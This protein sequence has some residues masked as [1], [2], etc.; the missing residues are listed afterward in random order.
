MVTLAKKVSRRLVKAEVV[1][2]ENYGCS[3]EDLK[4][5]TKKRFFG[6][7]IEHLKPCSIRGSSLQAALMVQTLHFL[8]MSPA[9]SLAAKSG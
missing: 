8:K 4:N 7:P 2:N 1:A 5:K 3:G 6:T 9:V